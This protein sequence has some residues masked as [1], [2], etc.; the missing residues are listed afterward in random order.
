[1][2]EN[3]ERIV[4]NFINYEEYEEKDIEQNIKK[5]IK[6]E[7]ENISSL[8]VFYVRDNDIVKVRLYGKLEN[9]IDPFKYTYEF[10]KENII[11]SVRRYRLTKIINE[12]EEIC[13]RFFV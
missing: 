2:N 1:L 7:C 4:F 5:L 3:I 13:S 10:N 12:N 11:N 6:D 9:I 8:D